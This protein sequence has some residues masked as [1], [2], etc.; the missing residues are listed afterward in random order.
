MPGQLAE[1]DHVPPPHFLLGKGQGLVGFFCIEL[2]SSGERGVL[3]PDTLAVHQ[4]LPRPLRKFLASSFPFFVED[5][6]MGRQPFHS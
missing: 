3:P 6:K 5:Q 2:L 4:A 1:G